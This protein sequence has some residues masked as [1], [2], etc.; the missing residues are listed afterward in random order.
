VRHGFHY[1]AIGFSARPFFAPARPH[2]PPI[3]RPN[4]KIAGPIY[5]PEIV[6]TEDRPFL[7]FG[8]AEGSA[9]AQTPYVAIS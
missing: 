9:V 8:L 1:N 2:A 5:I 4:F 3:F 7:H 6:I